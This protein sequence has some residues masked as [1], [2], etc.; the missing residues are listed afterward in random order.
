MVYHGRPTGHARAFSLKKAMKMSRLSYVA[1]AATD[2]TRNEWVCVFIIKNI[3]RE[4][5]AAGIPYTQTSKSKG[6]LGCKQ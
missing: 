6:P 5:F 3:G 1:D 2:A 4:Y